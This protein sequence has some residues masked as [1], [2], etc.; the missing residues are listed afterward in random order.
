MWRC[1]DDEYVARII[2]GCATRSEANTQVYPLFDLLSLTNYIYGYKE[3]GFLIL[4]QDSSTFP[5]KC[6]H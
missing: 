3:N 1:I 2:I 4:D 5:L 6:S